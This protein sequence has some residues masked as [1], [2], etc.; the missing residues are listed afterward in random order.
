MSAQTSIC[1]ACTSAPKSSVLDEY[2]RAPVVVVARVASVEKAAKYET[3]TDENGVFEIYDLPP[4]NYRLEP[5]L[6]TGLTIDLDWVR[7]SGGLN[8]DQPSETSVAFTLKPRGH[9]SIHLGFKSK[10]QK[11]GGESRPK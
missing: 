9:V 7:L 11:G 10:D 4:G 1:F 5:E 8:R 6:Q 2:E 3:T